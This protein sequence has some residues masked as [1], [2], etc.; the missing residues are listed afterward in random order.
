MSC[1]NVDVMQKKSDDTPDIWREYEA[2]RD[3]LEIIITRTTNSIDSDIQAV[4]MKVEATDATV[5][6]MQVQVNDLQTTIQA[7]TQS[8]NAP[9]LT[10]EQRSPPHADADNE[11]AHGNNEGFAA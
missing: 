9:R 4:Q 2:L 3:H 11:S 10:I 5:N 6:N 1:S 7:L 8:I